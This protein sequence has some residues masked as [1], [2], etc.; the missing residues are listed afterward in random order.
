MNVFFCVFSLVGE[1]LSES[2][3]IFAKFMGYLM[4]LFLAGVTV[5]F[6][7]QQLPSY[8]VHVYFP[9][10]KL[11]NREKFVLETQVDYYKKLSD[12]KKKYFEHRVARFLNNH[13]IIPR[14]NMVVT[15]EVRVLI[16]SS[17]VALTFG[18][19]QYTY[20][21][22]KVII[23]YPDIY[24]SN[25]TG[26]YHKGEFNPRNKALVFSWEHFLEGMK[27]DDDNINLGYHEFAHALHFEM[28]LNKHANSILFKKHFRQLLLELR[29][30]E[31]REKL[32]NST[33]FREYAFE[34][35]Y[36]FL[37]VLIESYFETPET[38]QAE[39]PLFYKNIRKILNQ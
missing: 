25:I 6:I 5:V 22:F 9:L 3:L 26:Q 21:S 35:K 33:Y 29:K 2:D 23:L 8:F 14:E 18:F 15:P 4:L 28:K 17:S 38:F 30:T 1:P 10:K 36:E 7:Y 13:P 20:Q 19:R 34:N 31:K 27:A 32:L 16:A 24:F 39:F 11:P 12:K 37:A